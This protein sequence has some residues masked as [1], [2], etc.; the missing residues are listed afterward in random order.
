MIKN[1]TDD[2]FLGYQA[3]R[4]V[5]N[6]RE[7]VPEFSREADW[8]QGGLLG[9]SLERDWQSRR[10]A[11]ESFLRQESR[12]ERRLIDIPVPYDETTITE[13]QGLL[14]E[15]IQSRSHSAATAF[16]ES[17]LIDREFIISHPFH[18]RP[19]I[20]NRFDEAIRMAGLSL[21]N[22]VRPI[23]TALEDIELERSSL[24]RRIY[25]PDQTIVEV[26]LFNSDLLSYLKRHPALMRELSPHRF[27]E[28]IAELLSARGYEITPTPRT[29]DGGFD[30]Y[31]AYKDS[32]GQFLYLVECKRFTPPTKV[33]V[34]IAR[35]LYGVVESQ[36]AGAGLIVTS[37]FF[38][39]DA[40]IYQR[41]VEFRLQFSDFTKISRWLEES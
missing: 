26:R 17:V 35:A 21:S 3:S 8:R 11:W 34:G 39:K 9:Y 2:Y 31:A 16:I 20:T 19:S 37:S 33:G 30:M 27:E 7:S 24:E 23:T 22:E 36:R 15:I 6:L 1:R 10:E 32:V 18:I 5:G 13:F 25:V 14:R 38:T 4:N 29:R 40:E 28:L 41:G 12:L